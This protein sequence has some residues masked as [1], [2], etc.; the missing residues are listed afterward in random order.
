MTLIKPFWIGLFNLILWSCISGSA[1][2]SLDAVITK[3][4]AHNMEKLINE[5]N[6]NIKKN[7]ST[8]SEAGLLPDLSGSFTF[9]KTQGDSSSELSSGETLTG[10]GATTQYAGAKLSLSQ[11]LTNIFVPFHTYKKLK[12]SVILANIEQKLWV[13]NLLLTTIST[14]YNALR[15][16][17]NLDLLNRIWENSKTSYTNIENQHKLGAASLIEL[18]D[19]KS[20]LSMHETNYIQE[21]NNYDNTLLNLNKLMGNPLNASIQLQD[22]ISLSKNIKLDP[23]LQNAN[24]HNLSIQIAQQKEA[25]SDTDLQL[26]I[27]SIYPSLTIGLDYYNDSNEASASFVKESEKNGFELTAA[28]SWSIYNKGQ[29]FNKLRNISLARNV[30]HQIKTLTKTT[31]EHELRSLY[32]NYTMSLKLLDLIQDTIHTQEQHFA[33]SQYLYQSGQI[34]LTELQ[35]SLINYTQSQQQEN[36]IILTIRQN[37]LRLLQ[38]AGKLTQEFKI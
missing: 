7:V 11:T 9:V 24:E 3:T 31:V 32:N 37:E 2:L 34:T 14:Y 23:L 35:G 1:P 15:L 27:D 4:L 29:R 17:K 25:I 28:L 10:S 38:L 19:A 20:R 21:K 5:N 8:K 12:Q 26:I 18:L 22:T 33:R 6:I 13:E 36:N 30:Q 16:K